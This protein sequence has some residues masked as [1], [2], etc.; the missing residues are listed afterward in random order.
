MGDNALGEAV[1]GT[2]PLEASLGPSSMGSISMGV[3]PLILWPLFLNYNTKT[4]K[5]PK[6][7]SKGSS[8]DTT[9]IMFGTFSPWLG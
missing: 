7:D 4:F 5:L 3:G 1:M 2:I 6:R 9:I 8:F